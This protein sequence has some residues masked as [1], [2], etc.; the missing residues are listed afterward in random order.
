M[1]HLNHVG[2]ATRDADQLA[3][4]LKLITGSEATPA[5]HVES[6]GV[7]VRFVDTGAC[8]LEILESLQPGSPLAR[9]ID[10]R[11][12]GL[13]H[14]AFTVVDIDQQLK[15]LRT[16]GFTP[17]SNEP[18]VGAGGK[19]IFFLH[20]K[21]TGRILI[22]ICQLAEQWP[23]RIVG[24]AP[25]LERVLLSTGLVRW[26]S[27]TAA[28]LIAARAVTLARPV[29]ES[30]RS[31]V[32]F[33]PTDRTA[34]PA[35]E[36]RQALICLTDAELRYAKH[37]QAQWPEAQLALLPATTPIETWATLIMQFWGAH[38]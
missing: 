22:E 13:H 36:A 29:V 20:P 2:L 17:L 19:R 25:A 16:A 15:R 31:V 10:L 14:I 26:G 6:E 38:E 37:I 34:L 7:L 5:E 9:H 30:C 12:E 27:Q 1:L 18:Q 24:A 21:T 11:G 4:L 33:Q 3:L 28:H 35:L 23:V 32:L 8:R